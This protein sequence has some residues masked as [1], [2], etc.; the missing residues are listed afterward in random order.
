VLD[1]VY[2]KRISRSEEKV[3]VSKFG[4]FGIDLAAL[5][6]FFDPPWRQSVESLRE[7]DKGFVSN[8]A[9]Y[10]LRALGRLTEAAQLFQAS[11]DAML[12]LKNWREAAVRSNNL[13]ELY[14]IIGNVK[15]ALA[16]A[17]RG[18]QF[19][20]KSGD[21]FW[22]MGIRTALGDVLHQAGILVKLATGQFAIIGRNKVKY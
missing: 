5:S 11:L 19:A 14:L 4:A 10:R 12:A 18:V 2:W 7:D 17:E 1:E 20:D 15:E 9:G 3:V 6:E 8:Q 22:K 21:E 13:S 16:Y